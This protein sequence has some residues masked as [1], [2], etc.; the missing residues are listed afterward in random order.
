MTNLIL[1]IL[2]STPSLSQIILKLIPETYNFIHEYFSI[3]L[4]DKDFKKTTVVVAYQ[5][6]KMNNSL[7][8]W[9]YQIY[10]VWICSF[11]SYHWRVYLNQDLN[12][13]LLLEPPPSFFP[14]LCHFLLK[15]S[16]LWSYKGSQ[17]LCFAQCISDKVYQIVYL[18]S[19]LFSL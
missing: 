10:A 17:S 19:C 18:L 15:K 1:L 3:Y 14:F 13:T 6:K 2:L 4:K 11:L 8:Y 5:I 12:N 16:D 9:Y 7:I